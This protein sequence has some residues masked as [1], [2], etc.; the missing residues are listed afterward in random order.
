MIGEVRL[1]E[2]GGHHHLRQWREI[3]WGRECADCGA[4]SP[5]ASADADLRVYDGDPVV[6]PDCG[7]LGSS[8]VDSDDGDAW[9][10]WREEGDSPDRLRPSALA[11]L[12]RLHGLRPYWRAP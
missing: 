3:D 7:L 8:S 6:C 10:T 12:R 9:V 4:G 2:L 1:S 5:L 11:A